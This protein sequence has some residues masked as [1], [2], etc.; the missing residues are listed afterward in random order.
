MASDQTIVYVTQ[1]AI[2]GF[3][4]IDIDNENALAIDRTWA[5]LSVCKYQLPMNFVIICCPKK[6]GFALS[7]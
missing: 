4:A 7:L 2:D 3:R 5:F 6:L 1:I